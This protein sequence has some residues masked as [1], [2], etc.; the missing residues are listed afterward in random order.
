MPRKA[1]YFASASACPANR[2]IADA[3]APEVG[4]SGQ[5]SEVN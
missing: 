3:V 5:R 4:V 1:T 2:R